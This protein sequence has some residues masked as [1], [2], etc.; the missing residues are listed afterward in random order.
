[1]PVNERLANWPSEGV[2]EFKDTW[3]KYRKN[4]DPVLK[5]LSL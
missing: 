4:L 2:I 5:G 3:V 1:M